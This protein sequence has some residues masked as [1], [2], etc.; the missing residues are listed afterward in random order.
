MSPNVETVDD[1]AA[2]DFDLPD[3]LV[4]RRPPEKR[5]AGRLLVLDRATQRIEH[6]L[7]VDLP[8]LLTAG[9]TLVLND[10]R[11]VRARLVG[12][13]KATGGRWEGLFLGESAGLWTVIGQCRGKLQAGES[14]VVRSP[15]AESGE[16]EL[17]LV[18]RGEGG[19]WR[20][21]PNLDGEAES[22]LDRFGAMPLPP[23][24]GRDADEQDDGRYQT[25]Y[26][27]RAGA[28]AAPTAGL[29]F[30]PE[31]LDACDRRGIGRTKV[32]LHVGLGTFRPVSAERLSDH[33]MHGEWCELSESSAS[34]LVETR[35]AGGRVV[36]V[37]TTCV[38]TLESAAARV[39]FGQAWSGETDLFIRPPY[40]FRAIDGLLTNFHLPRSTL[41]VLVSALAGREFVLEAYREAV[42]ERYR[43]FSYGDAML[44]L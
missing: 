37:G 26:A 41:L 20:V 12:S 21:R 22:L 2:Y 25:V 1:V 24:L 30:T 23:Y 5:D 35:E 10:T 7:V 15:R 17:E 18:S 9:D 6:R 32:T 34:R 29:H 8:D 36:A 42:L 40:D 39:G 19:A 27:N 13:R 33:T 4:A 43:F 14:L 44:V 16:L 28:V 38:R 31:L 3:E 11:V